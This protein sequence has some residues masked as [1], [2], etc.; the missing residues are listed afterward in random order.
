MANFTA[1]MLDQILLPVH[2][3]SHG[4]HQ[5][6]DDESNQ[7][8]PDNALKSDIEPPLRSAAG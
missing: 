1:V 2:F 3:A 5:A 6:N 7:A 4:K 8:D